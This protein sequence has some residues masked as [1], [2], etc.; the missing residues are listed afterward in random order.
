M[1]IAG[2]EVGKVKSIDAVEGTNAALLTM[3]LK[4]SAL[5]LHE[6]ATAKIRPRIFLEGNFFVDL[7]PGTPGSPQLDSGDTIKITQ[8]ATPV[9]LDQVLTSLQSD[10]REDLQALLDGLN[11]AFN[12]K[13]TRGEDAT[14]PLARGP[15]RGAS[16]STT[17]STT[18]RPPSAR[19]RRCS[20]RC[21][22]PSPTATSRG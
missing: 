16:P 17:R 7:K 14:S 18:S 4:D 9:Q 22:A 10:S 15:D 2:V 13:P 21:S 12:S 11:T 5:P 6:D 19:P 3:E 8:T 20:R 1:R